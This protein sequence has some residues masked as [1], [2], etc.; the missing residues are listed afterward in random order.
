MATEPLNALEIVLQQVE[1]LLEPVIDAAE[2]PAQRDL[3]FL[4]LGWDINALT[5]LPMQQL[6]EALSSLPPL[7]DGL[8]NG[9]DLADF[10]A[11]LDAFQAAG[12]LIGSVDE[13]EAAFR[14]GLPGVP[15]DAL[16]VDF[17]NYLVVGYVARGFPRVFAFMRI[18]TLID[19]PDVSP[20]PR[21]IV[22]AQD[23]R[24]IFDG[25]PRPV[26][27]FDRLPETAQRPGRAVR[28]GLL[29]AGLRLAGG[30]ER[31]R[32]TACSRDWRR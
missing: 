15:V 32:P 20:S 30:R 10:G 12:D 13:I 31:R 27:R 6:D 16:A 4:G 14:N 18:A 11:I 28:G 5:G 24:L 29:A 8:T 26:L 17:L 19:L 1:N 2:G 25:K 3:L 9:L 21:A 23:G 7:I 22:Q